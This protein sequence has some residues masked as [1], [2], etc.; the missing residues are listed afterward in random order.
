MTWSMPWFFAAV[1]A[2]LALGLIVTAT[3]ASA[4]PLI[5]VTGPNCM[6]VAARVM[7]LASAVT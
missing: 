7:V 5:M 3:P 4:P 2:V 6:A 1:P